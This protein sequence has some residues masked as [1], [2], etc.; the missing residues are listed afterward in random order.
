MGLGALSWFFGDGEL[1]DLSFFVVIV[2][3]LMMDFGFL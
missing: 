2:V 1:R 3:K